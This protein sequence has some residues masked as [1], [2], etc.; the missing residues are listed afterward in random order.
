MSATDKQ[1]PYVYG[2][3]P[4]ND[5]RVKLQDT[6]R[7]RCIYM[8]V[9]AC[10]IC[11]VYMYCTLLIC[12]YYVYVICLCNNVLNFMYILYIELSLVE[13]LEQRYVS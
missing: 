13:E 7:G 5:D 1:L 4:I 3:Y 2:Q 12:V 9:Y 6:E 11:I 8:C 10:H